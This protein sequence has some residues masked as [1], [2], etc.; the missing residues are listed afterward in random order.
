MTRRRHVVGAFGV[1]VLFA[2]AAFLAVLA[3]DVVRAERAVEQG[4]ARFGAVTGRQG[5]WDADT[6]LPQRLTRRLLGL[7]DDVA[8]RAAVQ[9]FRLARPRQPVQQFSQLAVRAG[10]DRALARATRE[11][12]DPRHRA[13]LHNLRGALA[14]E[15][16]RLGSDSAPSIRRAVTQFRLAV[17]LDPG[18]ED[19]QYNLELALRLLA[20]SGDTSGG[21]GER[22]ATPASGSGSATAGS[23]Y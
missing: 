13:A 20:R 8:H 1:V 9:R 12:D 14:L 18:N 10:A 21:S 6:T 11:Q 5:M 16:A 17:E 2:A 22:A 23:G 7:D 15:E 3:A 4:D 19:A